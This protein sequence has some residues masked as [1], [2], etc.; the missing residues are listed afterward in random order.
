MYALY[1][2]GIASNYQPLSLYS[3]HQYGISEKP[4]NIASRAIF[5]MLVSLRYQY[6]IYNFK[7][8]NQ[9]LN[10]FHVSKY[11]AQSHVHTG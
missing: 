8:K 11:H 3:I 5:M 2:V 6:K 1:N 7:N 9:M 10:S 4:L